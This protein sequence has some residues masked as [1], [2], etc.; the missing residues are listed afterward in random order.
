MDTDE[1][2]KQIGRRMKIRRVELDMNQDDLGKKL[3]LRQAEVSGIESGRR[4]LRIEQA[5]RIADALQ[6]TV[7][8]LVGEA[9]RAEAGNDD[10][11]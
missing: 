7:A 2:R 1:I 3:G 5:V 8:Y 6:T 9:P 10:N 4:I 11:R